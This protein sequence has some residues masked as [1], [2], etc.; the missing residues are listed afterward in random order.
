MKMFKKLIISAAIAVFGFGLFAQ[1]SYTSTVT[2]SLFSKDV[3]NYM[4]VC[5]WSE[6]SPENAFMYFQVDGTNYYLGFAKDFG[7]FYWGT[8]YIGNLNNSTKTVT[9]TDAGTTK[10]VAAND[11]TNFSFNNLFGFG[12][13]G[14]R[15]NLNFLNS[16]SNITDTG[17]TKT[18]TNNRYL[19]ASLTAGLAEASLG[20][21]SLKPWAYVSYTINSNLTGSK[22]VT[23]TADTETTVDS[24]DNTFGLGA[25][26]AIDLSKSEKRK[27]TLDLAVSF[28]ST[29]PS[30]KDNHKAKN[31]SIGIPVSYKTVFTA[32]EKIAFGFNAGV[33]T[34][35]NFKTLESEDK[36]TDISI[37]PSF[38]AGLTYDTLKKV[39]F[40]AGVG[41]AVP[42]MTFEKS[43]TE[44]Q[45]KKVTTFYGND[46]S[47]S[48]TSGLTIEPVKNLVIDCSWNILGDLFVNN[49]D[50]LTTGSTNFWYTVNNVLIHRIYFQVSYKF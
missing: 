14:L 4:S 7:S 34:T 10:E 1:S 39:K 43:V 11:N 5:N 26:A 8:Y 27:E 50:T 35:L 23:T 42:Y 44:T 24:R 36:E 12:N 49:R 28:A 15:V 22:V 19:N 32:S 20:S 3:D 40:N 21:L 2:N 16:G 25:G 37:T 18:N 31:T 17:T 33:N 29:N 9:T 45:T 6:V 47:I 46:G 38:G 48:Y 41:F 13:L 30:D